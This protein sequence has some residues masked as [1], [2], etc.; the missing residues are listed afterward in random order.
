M[1][2]AGR[3]ETVDAEAKEAG[4]PNEVRLVFVTPDG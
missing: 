2:I 1:N 3:P 4:N